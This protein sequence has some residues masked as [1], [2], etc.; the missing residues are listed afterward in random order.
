MT[1][2]RGKIIEHV[3]SVV[4]VAAALVAAFFMVKGRREG[5]EEEK[6]AAV[7]DFLAIPDFDYADPFERALLKDVM[8]LYYPGRESLNEKT[9]EAVIAN[10]EK[11][12]KGRV[13]AGNVR[14]SISL[15]Q[16][17]L[18][19]SMYLKFLII[20]L[21]VLGL[22]YYGVQTMAVF[23]FA[24]KKAAARAA[25][26]GNGW[27]KRLP[28]F[29][30][31]TVKFLLSM[32]LFSPAYTIAYSMR[33]EFNTDTAFFLVVLGV[34]SN[35]LLITYANKFYAFL[36]A[37]GRKGYV[38]TALAK[39][40]DDSY[41]FGVPGGI[42]LADVLRLFKSFR[43]HVFSHIFS[44][45]RKQYLST[46]KEQASFLITGLI[47]IEMALNIHG[48]LCYEM[49][50]QLLYGN[51]DIVVLI[52][53]LLFFTVKGTEIASDIMIHRENLKYENRVR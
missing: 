9:A 8:N 6:T 30:K 50:Q 37:E 25:P 21:L 44:Q 43:G 26:P 17:G 13:F 7:R 38:E 42:A 19:L 12:F 28:R 16:T 53:L 31:N 41:A 15:T 40:L 3:L 29:G 32:V 14:R 52:I 46:L 27:R 34:V 24:R 45:A 11:E 33:T 36:M 49:L 35:G 5:A 51:Y 22:T 48:H 1:A 18:I 2:L 20:Y 39:N 4:L 23:R 47:I 10:K